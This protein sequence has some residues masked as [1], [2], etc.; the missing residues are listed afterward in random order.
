VLA[1]GGKTIGRRL[2][3]LISSSDRAA[4]TVGGQEAVSRPLD[5][6]PSSRE[7]L[8]EIIRPEPYYEREEFAGIKVL[9]GRSSR[10]EVLGLKSGDIIRT[11]EGKPLKSVDAA[12]QLIDDALSTGS[13]IVVSIERDG[14]L[15]SMYFDGSKLA[16]ESIHLSATPLPGSPGT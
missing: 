12:W 10:L 1:V 16:Q 5:N 11:I 13:S 6:F 15:T 14:N 3:Q 4:V 9:P 8:S 7:D 2:A